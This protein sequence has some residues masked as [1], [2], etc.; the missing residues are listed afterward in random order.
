MLCH[1]H[2]HFYQPTYHVVYFSILISQTS[3][4]LFTSMYETLIKVKRKFHLITCH[5]GTQGSQTYSSTL[6]LTCCFMLEMNQY[7]LYRRL[8]W[9]QGMS[10]WL[11]KISSTS[12]LGP[13]TAHPVAS[14][15]T[16]YN[17]PQSIYT[18]K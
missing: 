2:D 11:E 4:L 9:P 7:P 8:G 3:K 13:Q 17:I 18:N 12:G 1:T 15:Y 10:G 14:C 6:S 5:E 16:D